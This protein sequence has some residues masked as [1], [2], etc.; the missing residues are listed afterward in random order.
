MKKIY[1]S[2][3]IEFLDFNIDTILVA[4]GG[5]SGTSNANYNLGIRNEHQHTQNGAISNANGNSF[6]QG[7]KDFNY[8]FD[9]DYDF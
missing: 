4:S 6:T 9:L 8:T 1:K 2:P 7:A 5:E 3:V